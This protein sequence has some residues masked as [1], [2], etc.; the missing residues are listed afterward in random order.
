[1]NQEETL[2]YSTVQDIILVPQGGPAQYPA[3]WHN[4]AEFVLALREGSRYQIQGIPYSLEE[5]DL[6]LI[7]RRAPFSSFS[8][9]TGCLKAIWIWPQRSAF[10]PP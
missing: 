4:A 7:W 9:Q 6:L 10:F 1:M 2:R 3:H 5:G 8:F